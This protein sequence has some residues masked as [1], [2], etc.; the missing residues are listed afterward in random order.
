MSFDGFLDLIVLVL[1]C[2]N[3]YFVEVGG[4]A[5]GAK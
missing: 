2:I 3:I 5:G 4:W 1:I